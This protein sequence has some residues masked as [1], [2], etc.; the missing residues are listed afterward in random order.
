MCVY[1]YSQKRD[2]RKVNQKLIEIIGKGGVGMGSRD[3]NGSEH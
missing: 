1:V 2:T 3:K